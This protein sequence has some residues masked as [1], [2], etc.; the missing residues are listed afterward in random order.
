MLVTITF[1]AYFDVRVEEL[2]EERKL[3]V[4]DKVSVCVDN[5]L[6]RI[7][8]KNWAARRQNNK[9]EEKTRHVAYVEIYKLLK[10]CV[11]L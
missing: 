4:F 2:L 11:Y 9:R 10:W 8:F 6:R 3:Y 1:D 5:T 7:G